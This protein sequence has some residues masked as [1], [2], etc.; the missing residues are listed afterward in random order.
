MKKALQL[1]ASISAAMVLTSCS[2]TLPVRG[3]VMNSSETFTGTA[4]GYMDGGGNMTLVT[5]RGATCKGNF[6]YVSRRD[7]EGVFSCDDGRTGPFTFVSTGTR[8]TGKGDL[9]GERFIFTFG[10]Q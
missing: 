3:N 5:S 9:G 2:M 4:T 1:A 10:K 6:V 7:G 8:G